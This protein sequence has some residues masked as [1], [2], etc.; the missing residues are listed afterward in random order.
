MITV[1]RIVA[2][3]LAVDFVSGLVHWAEDTFGTET[4]P[5]FGRWVVAPNVEHHRDAA[6][7]VRK[8]WLGSNWDLALVGV[9]LVAMS[10]VGGWYGPGVAVFAVAGANANQ[11]HKWCH[12]PA[13]A[14]WIAR[15]L[16]RT[17]ILQRPAHHGRHHTGDKN[18]AYC[19]VTPFVNPV[20]DRFG[21]WRGLERL[22]VPFTGAP[23]REDLRHLRPFPWVRARATRRP[24][25]A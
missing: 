5:V 20:L 10:L 14:P 23:R 12:A 25:R 7:F 19:V 22:V 8:S 13:R 16:W 15:A 18:S 3:L 4:T 24:G 11:I 17:G 1:L 21:F 9:I 6:A 2:C